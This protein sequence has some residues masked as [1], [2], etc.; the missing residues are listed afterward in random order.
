MEAWVIKR[1]DGKYFDS[2]YGVWSKYWGY[3]YALKKNALHDINICNLQG[4]K[5]VKV[6]I[7]E[8]EE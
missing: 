2:V 7:E 1:N 3:F 5:P 8:V 6:R 4:C